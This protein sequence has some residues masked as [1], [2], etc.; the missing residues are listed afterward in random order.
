MCHQCLLHRLLRIVRINKGDQPAISIPAGAEPFQP[1][2]APA[3]KVLKRLAAFVG[4]LYAGQTQFPAIGEKQCA[5]ITDADDNC[6]VNV[7]ELAGF[8]CNGTARE[9]RENDGRND[10]AGIGE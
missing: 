6:C 5:P 10:R 7:G 2:A 4:D 8:L 1:Y 3:D 9:E